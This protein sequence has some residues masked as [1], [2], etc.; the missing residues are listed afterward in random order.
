MPKNDRLFNDSSIWDIIYY[1]TVA[2][3]YDIYT[4][5]GDYFREGCQ[6]VYAKNNYTIVLTSLHFIAIFSWS[7][8]GDVCMCKIPNIEY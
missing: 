7:F 1:E 5:W 2:D 6:E 3:Q 8:K 4:Y